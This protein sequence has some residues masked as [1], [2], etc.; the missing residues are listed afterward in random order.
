MSNKNLEIFL[1]GYLEGK[2]TEIIDDTPEKK[3]RNYWDRFSNLKKELKVIIKQIRHFPSQEELGRI[4]LSGVARAVQ[5]HGGFIAVREK[6]GYKIIKQASGHWKDFDNVRDTLEEII[7]K[8]KEFPSTEQLKELGYNGLVT[9]IS[10]YHGGIRNVRE[11]MGY[12]NEIKPDGY[13]KDWS[14]LKKEIN[15]LKKKLGHFPTSTEMRKNGQVSLAVGIKE[16]HGGIIK[17]R[18]KLGIKE[19]KKLSGYWNSFE[20][21]DYE[22][23]PIIKKL[24]H[25]PTQAELIKLGKSSLAMAIGKYHGGINNVK[26]RLGY[27]IARKSHGYWNDFENI[28]KELETICNNLEESP[29]QRYLESI[30]RQDLISAIGKYHGGLLKVKEKLGYE[31]TQKPKGYWQNWGNIEKVLNKMI[32][33]L[34]RFPTFTDF[35]NSNYSTIPG[36]IKKFHGGIDCIME[37]MGYERDYLPNGYWK[38]FENVKNILSELE[39]KLGHFPSASEMNEAGYTSLP[40]AINKYHKGLH[41][42]AKKLGKQTQQK[43]AGYWT[44]NKTK[45][46]CLEFIEEYGKFPTQLELKNREDKYKALNVGINK[47]GGFSR[48]K[49][50]LKVE[51][52]KKQRGYWT[53]ER[54][55]KEAKKIVNEKG[56]LPT[57]KELYDMERGDLVGAISAHSSF[58]KIKRKLGL[59]VNKVE[60][61]YWTENK[62]LEDC[63][64]ILKEQGDLPTKDGLSEIGRKELAGAIEKN[65]GYPYYRKKL[66]LSLRRRQIRFWNKENTYN[67]AKELYEKY[68]NLPTEDKLRELGFSTLPAA[69]IEHFNGLVNL[70][71]LL[72]NEFGDDKQELNLKNSSYVQEQLK[73]I[74]KKHRLKRFP[75]QETLKKL[76]YNNLISAIKKYHHGFNSVRNSMG[77]KTVAKNGTWQDEE[78]VLNLAKKLMEKNHWKT[79]PA[80][81]VLNEKGY[82]MFPNAIRSLYGSVDVFR[83][84]LYEKLG[85]E[86]EKDNLESFLENYVGN[87]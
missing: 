76:G 41:E 38:N 64:E 54:I 84:R 77:E 86:H 14:N 78:Y 12:K 49:R 51:E 37:K 16:Y 8:T 36:A 83:E 75:G 87:E 79:W 23:K 43:E 81:N 60:D 68:G 3:P 30:G 27:E 48:I 58:T 7:A 62:I 34:G 82:S 46:M 2:N 29:S 56:H 40:S 72:R 1:E 4:G 50:L 63:K 25:F 22:L 13:W 47:N 66:G 44:L 28:K 67:K 21:V 32:K 65:G 24:K 5:K 26:E 55:L 11:L 39:I 33:K 18:E 52:D 74:Q 85:V 57:Q 42:I 20:N 17:V 6:M 59:K 9:G 53:E 69:A 45:N 19:N 10:D 15:K 70:R 73:K 31:I 80:E 61:G 71:S 35:K